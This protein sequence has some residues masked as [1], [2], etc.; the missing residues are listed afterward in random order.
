MK[1][2]FNNTAIFIRVYDV[3]ENN[4]YELKWGMTCIPLNDCKKPHIDTSWN[5]YVLKR[6]A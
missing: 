1:F 5:Y 3:I 4:I 2:E 6:I